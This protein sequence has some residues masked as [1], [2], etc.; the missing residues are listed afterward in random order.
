MLSVILSMFAGI[1]RLLPAKLFEAVI[2]GQTGSISTIWDLEFLLKDYYL[3]VTTDPNSNLF[4]KGHKLLHIKF[5]LI[6]FYSD[7]DHQ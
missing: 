1:K 6:Q 7:A 2:R 4:I 5:T 3:V